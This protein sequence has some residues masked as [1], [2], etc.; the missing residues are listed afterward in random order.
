MNYVVSRNIL[1][2]AWER[3][4]LLAFCLCCFILHA[5]LGDC[6]LISFGALSMVPNSIDSILDRCL[7]I[8]F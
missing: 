6:V 8:T 7:S 3:A 1:G 5:V 4:V 2:I